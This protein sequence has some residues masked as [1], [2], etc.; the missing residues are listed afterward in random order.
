MPDVN[1]RTDE[2]GGTVENRCRFAVEIVKRLRESLGK[3]LAILYRHTPVGK[4]YWINDSITLA[5]RVI[6]AGADVLDISPARDKLVGDLAAPFKAR[7]P[8]TPVIAV[9]GMEEPEAANAA[10]RDQRC[11]LVAV[12]RSLIC[13]AQWPVKVREGRLDEI[14]KCLKCDQG[15][16]GN[17]KARKPVFCQQWKT[18]PLAQYAGAD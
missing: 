3:K 9:R 14:V 2:Y 8:K 5:E 17:L 10:I 18:D 1:T 6:D 15:C 11:D 16:F 4:A 13:D 12:G 7:F